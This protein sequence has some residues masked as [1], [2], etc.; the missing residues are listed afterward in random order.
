MIVIDYWWLWWLMIV[1]NITVIL[2]VMMIP[3]SKETNKYIYIKFSNKKIY[4][5]LQCCLVLA[6]SRWFKPWTLS[7][8]H[9][10]PRFAIHLPSR[11]L[12]FGKS[13]SLGPGSFTWSRKMI[14]TQSSH[15]SYRVQPTILV[16][17]QIQEIWPMWSWPSGFV[18]LWWWRWKYFVI[19]TDFWA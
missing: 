10:H 12:R 16:V 14:L 5:S 18:S 13:S 11:Y 15:F 6:S 3:Q 4:L 19:N 9:R 17:G 1:I 2:V 7:M 8:D